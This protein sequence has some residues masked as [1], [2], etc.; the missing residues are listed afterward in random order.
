MCNDI[1]R[2]ES[3]VGKRGRREDEREGRREGRKEV[4][5]CVCERM[6]QVGLTIF[7][8]ELGLYFFF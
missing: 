4:C 3:E 8:L 5:V 1:G 6:C 2:V 7:G